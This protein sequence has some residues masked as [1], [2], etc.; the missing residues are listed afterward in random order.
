MNN[1]PAEGAVSPSIVNA[2]VQV[3]LSADGGNR[4]KTGKTTVGRFP[5]AC[6]STAVAPAMLH[7]KAATC[8]SRQACLP[9]SPSVLPLQWML[10]DIQRAAACH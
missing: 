7:V 4:R 8:D 3:C 2:H 5:P 10:V 6:K 1:P 9:R